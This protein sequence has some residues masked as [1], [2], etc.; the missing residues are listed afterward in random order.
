MDKLLTYLDI[1]QEDGTQNPAAAHSRVKA[2]T[3]GAV[4]SRSPAGVESTLGGSLAIFFGSGARVGTGLEVIPGTTFT[5]P[6]GKNAYVVGLG[7]ASGISVS[8][9]TTTFGFRL[10][11]GAGANAPAVCSFEVK[12]LNT[13][14][15]GAAV[16]DGLR[17]A[18]V[19]SVAAG[20]TAD[21]V[22]TRNSTFGDPS[23]NKA[24]AKITNTST[25]ADTTVSLVRQSSAGVA[26][27]TASAYI[28]A[29]IS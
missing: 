1:A 10:Q 11:Q 5:L 28:F 4:V 2:K 27:G 25:N 8:G 12:L 20:A 7:L 26:A 3:N 21:A 17:N 15:G 13:G 18:G 29:L 6:P 24:V 14:S 19:L 16:A 22:T 9:G 23:G